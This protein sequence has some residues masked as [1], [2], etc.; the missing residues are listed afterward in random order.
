MMFFF[1]KLDEIHDSVIGG[2]KLDSIINYY[3]LEKPDEFKIN[4]LGEDINYN[5]NDKLPK[6][7]VED[8]FLLSDDEST[9]F[10]EKKD[11]YYVIEI[12]ETENKQNNLEN[13]KVFKDVKKNL[14]SLNKR[15]SMSEI[16]GKI[17]QNSFSK[18]DFDN[19]SKNKNVPIQKISLEGI[20]DTKILK[21]GIVN[22]IY[23]FPEKKVSASYNI[24]LT[25]NFLVYVDKIIDVNV[26]EN[27]DDYKK[28]F[29]LTKISVTNELFNTYDKYIKEKY[30]IDINYKALK[31]IK[32]YF[33]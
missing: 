19:F 5:K 22:Q 26:D 7:L 15:K 18:L 13:K 29:N 10:V 28:Y 12:F 25:E 21:V 6:E 1:K 32:D 33:N 3:N 20:N 17:N 16:I 11:K 2:K 31:S 8:I 14:L 24:Q 23:N 9:S 30:E 4:K 27:S